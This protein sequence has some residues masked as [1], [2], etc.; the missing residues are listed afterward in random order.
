MLISVTSFFRNPLAFEALKEKVFPKLVQQP[1]D[2][3]LRIWVPGCS[4]GQEAYSIAMSFVEF[5][6]QA[7]HARKLQLFA[8]Y[9]N[10]AVLDKGRAGLYAKSLVHD[11]SRERLRRFFVEENGDY[12]VAKFLR[13]MV[14]FARQNLLS[15]PPFS[16]MDLVSC[17]NLLIYL[18]QDLQ[19]KILSTFH[20]ALKPGG[21]LFLGESE[22]T[23]SLRDLFETV[24]KNNKSFP[25]RLA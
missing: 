1:R 17:R 21:F 19:Q 15:D 11:L 2:K 6:E 8:T 18:E 24:N 25:K 12:R 23:G 16:Q 9:V 13:E 20:Y 10:G 22:S 14:L 5:S 4:T 3:P 7:G